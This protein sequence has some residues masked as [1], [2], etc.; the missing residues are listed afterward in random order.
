MKK[1]SSA[2]LEKYENDGYVVVEDVLESSTLKRL[3]D[4]TDEVVA[5]A[6]ELTTHSE[7][8]DLEES[9]TPENPRVR[10]IKR[11]HLVHDFYLKLARH[12]NILSALTPILGYDI[13]LHGGG[14]VNMKSA[15]YGAAVEWHQDWAFYP[16]TNQ[17]VLAV[18]ILL[19][20]MTS[21]NGPVLMV[22]GTH[23]GPLHNHHSDGAFCGAIDQQETKLDISTAQEVHAKAGSISIH[24]ARLVHGSSMNR[25]NDQ[26]RIL[27]FE[28]TAADAWP[29]LGIGNIE[30]FNGR[31]VQG[32]AT[33][34][35]RLE[36]VPVRMPY[37]PAVFQGSIYENQ[38]TLDNRFFASDKD[39]VA[40][41]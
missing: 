28:F 16:H 31:I 22:P 8:L 20:D 14:K 36:D 1:I 35:P 26:R 24:H 18:G 10:R 41:S 5:S 25:S 6:A 34:Q 13:R 27:F 37:P 11:P 38:R 2:Q 17:D 40:A 23:K 9:H 19:D 15:G 32:Q 33:I 12:P 29:L 30:E 4:V 3:R 21:E 39:E 7:A